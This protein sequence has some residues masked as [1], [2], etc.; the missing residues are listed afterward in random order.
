[1]SDTEQVP[2]EVKPK[3]QYNKTGNERN[4]LWK[5]ICEENNITQFKKGSEGYE[6][7]RAIYEEEK[8]KLKKNVKKTTIIDTELKIDTQTTTK[9]TEASSEPKSENIMKTT[10]KSLKPDL[11]ITIGTESYVI[12]EKKQDVLKSRKKTQMP[13]SPPKLIRQETAHPFVQRF[14]TSG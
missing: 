9:T 7:V 11:Q 2:V 3:R 14:M 1:M 12:E 5:R 10:K 4:N 8:K 13:T 6:K